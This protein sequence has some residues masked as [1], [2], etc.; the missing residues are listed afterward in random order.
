[1]CGVA[2]PKALLSTPIGNLT[3]HWEPSAAIRLNDAFLFASSSSWWDPSLWLQVGAPPS[4]RR[5]AKLAK[6]VAGFLDGQLGH[7]DLFVIKEPRIPVLFEHWLEAARQAGF[8]C[9]IVHVH[10]HPEEVAA[11]L[12]E[13]DGLVRDHSYLLWVKNNLLGERYTRD[14]PRVFLSYDDVLRDWRGSLERL[15]AVLDLKLDLPPSQS[16]EDFLSPELRHHTA[17]T[18]V[19]DDPT[20]ARWASRIYAALQGASAHGIDTTVMNCVFDEFVAWDRASR[21]GIENRQQQWTAWF[22]QFRLLARLRRRPDQWYHR[23]FADALEHQ[24]G[25]SRTRPANC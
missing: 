23:W 3:G 16:V 25:R 6:K 19:V 2:L 21:N 10:R 1:M 13:R 15:I 12:R 24:G 18:E 20:P 9:K 17:P 7:G 22:L 8:T 11:S 5:L 4:P 14:Y